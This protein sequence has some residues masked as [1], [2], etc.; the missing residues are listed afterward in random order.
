MKR[1]ISGLFGV[2]RPGLDM[3]RWLVSLVAVLAVQ[4]TGLANAPV[5]LAASSGTCITSDTLGCVTL[6]VNISPVPTTPAVIHLKRLGTSGTDD[7]FDLTPAGNGT[8][9]SGGPIWDTEI[10]GT[11][12][13]SNPTPLNAYFDITVTGSATGSLKNVNMCYNSTQ[14][15]SVKTINGV[16]TIPIPVVPLTGGPGTGPGGVKGQV[17]IEDQTGAIHPCPAGDLVTFTG[18]TDKVVQF[19]SGGNYDSTAVLA[20]GTY[21]IN[22][23]CIYGNNPYSHTFNGVVVTAGK[24]TVV[25]PYTIVSDLAPPPDVQT[26][27]PPKCD[28]GGWTTVICGGIRT[29]ITMIDWVRDTVIVPFLQEKPYDQDAPD[30]QPVYKAWQNMR[31]VASLLFLLL[32]FLVIFGTAIGWDNYTVKK[33]L[34]RLVAAALLVPF[35]WYICAGLIDVGNILGQGMFALLSS[36]IP[37]PSIDFTNPLDKLFLGGILVAGTVAFFGA[38]ATMAW[39]VF[40]SFAVALAVTFL[41]LVLRKLLISLLVILSPFA[42]LAFILPNTEKWFSQWREN[43][44]KLVMMYPL[45]MVLFELGRFFAWAAGNSPVN[46]AE[47]T[48]TPFIQ[49][50][51]YVVPLFMIPW[52]FSWA[53][54]ALGAGR[55]GVQRAGGAIDKRWGKGSKW[56]KDR[57]HVRQTKFAARA[58]ESKR[59]G[60]NRLGGAVARGWAAKR[61]GLGGFTFGATMGTRK[62]GTSRRPLAAIGIGAKRSQLQAM[63]KSAHDHIEE[64]AESEATDRMRERMPQSTHERVHNISEGEYSRLLDARIA[65]ESRA[66]KING[67]EVNNVALTSSSGDPA[68]AVDAAR[69]VFNNTGDETQLI[70]ALKASNGGIDQLEGLLR[71]ETTRGEHANKAVVGAVLKR[72]S[73]SQSGIDRAQE[74]AQGQI[75]EVRD[76][77]GRLVRYEGGNGKDWRGTASVLG[78]DDK[79][80]VSNQWIDIWNRS[81]SEGAAI[82]IKKSIAAAATDLSASD[83]TGN[84]GAQTKRLLAYIDRQRRSGN[85]AVAD[86]AQGDLNAAAGQILG[87]APLRARILQNTQVALAEASTLD[88]PIIE[89]AIGRAFAAR[90]APQLATPAVPEK[91][92]AELLGATGNDLHYVSRVRHDI[93]TE[94]ETSGGQSDTLD[95]L[96]GHLLNN[97]HITPADLPALSLPAPAPLAAGEVAL[98][99]AVSAYLLAQPELARNADALA[100]IERGYATDDQYRKRVQD[101][102][103][104]QMPV[105][106]PT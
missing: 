105:R 76:E 18:P 71:E 57:D 47:K 97:E 94:M 37:T 6:V 2:R 68:A 103:L 60:E 79:H 64:H 91:V 31:N 106:P 62:D 92:T 29:A 65:E 27:P 34:P 78:G 56:A 49:I 87:S 84:S 19:G 69:E 40:I 50:I 99:P 75:K 38:V 28:A 59:P 88:A 30:I 70:A 82:D 1:W 89:P 13:S 39:A 16:K 98:D 95:R 22:V 67:V 43:L 21:S 101:A 3:R 52:T 20:A 58:L 104:H 77:S 80:T 5:A 83:L 46:V 72:L 35:S 11:T 55:K 15:P 45:I 86:K 33:A 51:A 32:F 73:S 36:V 102:V 17:S 12:C 26:D 81:M 9:T 48:V 74:L 44:F 14:P 24:Y 7:S 93:E 41:T 25:P 8:Y 96:R 54:K 23:R 42:F 63:Q 10:T 66:L 61:S 4:A 53:G 85:H 90:T 100:R